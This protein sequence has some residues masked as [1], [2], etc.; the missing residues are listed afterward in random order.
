MNYDNAWLQTVF[1][2]RFPELGLAPREEQRAMANYVQTSLTRGRHLLAEAGVGTGKSFAYLI[3][4]IGH[5]RRTGL[6]LWVATRTIALQEQLVDKDLPMVQTLLREDFSTQL[7]KGKEHYLCPARLAIALKRPDH[8]PELSALSRWSRLTTTGDRAEA[9]PV[10]EAVWQTVN[11]GEV[12]PCARQCTRQAT[13][14]SFATRQGWQHAKGVLVTNHHQFFAD[15]AL[16]GSGGHLF[17]LPGAIVLDEAHALLDAA[18]DVLGHQTDLTELPAAARAAAR[19]L[20]RQDPAGPRLTTLAAQLVDRL[21]HAIVWEASEEASRFAIRCDET[22]I[23]LGEHLLDVAIATQ[24][25]LGGMPASPD[26]ATA[27][28]R[29][30]RA[31]APLHGLVR[32]EVHVA[33][34]EGDPVRR[35]AYRLASAPRDLAGLFKTRLFGR[36]A[37]VILTSATLSLGGDFSYLE[38]ALGVTTPLTCSVGTPFD[39]SRQTR[40]YLPDDLPDPSVDADAFYAAALKRLEALLEATQ[41]RALVLYTARTRASEGAKHL[42]AWGRFPILHQE[43]PSAELLER[44]RTEG[45]S[46]LLGTAYW[47]GIDVPGEPLSCVVI[48]KL[49]FPVSDPVLDAERQEAEERGEDSFDSVLLP[50]MLMRLRQ[51]TGRLIRR[52]SDRGVI[53]ILDPRA[54]TRS[55]GDRV[56]ESLPDAPV[57][58]TLDA[59]SDFLSGPR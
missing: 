5:L 13:C 58:S 30:E 38:T 52:S 29:L 39:L 41:G 28:A 43:R 35:R 40:L 37:P 49:P 33:W 21:R 34:V 25:V 17:A 27:Q 54:V 15:M 36:E 51:G 45:P 44:F 56:R 12:G 57:L 26:R 7:A 16:R 55:Y 8:A 6:P 23:A 42:K 14:P 46:V 48:V 22:L 31:T 4:G 9:P 1:D 47:E 53:A 18:R 59:I 19:Q 2:R 11:W 3:P 50:Q 24:E 32:P 20:P 10:P